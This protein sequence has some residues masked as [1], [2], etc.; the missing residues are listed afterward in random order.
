LSRFIAVAQAKAYA[1]AP[2][3]QGEKLW[4][5]LAAYQNSEP[6]QWQQYEVDWLAQIGTQLGIGLQ[7]AEYLQQV[8]IQATQLAKASA[9]QRIAEQQ[10]RLDRVVNKIRESLDLDVIFASATQ[11]LR[12]VL[13]AD[14][15]VI[16]RFDRN[17][18]GQFIAESVADGWMSIL[19][20][21]TADPQLCQ[22]VNDCSLKLL[23]N[24]SSDTHLKETEGG[25]FSR[26]EVF[27]VCNDVQQGGFSDCYLQVLNTYQ[28]QAY[29]IVALFRGQRLWGLLAAF[30]N[31]APRVWQEDEVHLLTE[32]GSHLGIALQQAGYLKQVKAQAVQLAKTTQ[33]QK[34]LSKTVDKIRYSLD[35]ETIFQT[36]TQEVRQLLKSDRVVIY[37][38]NPDWSGEFVAESV[39]E[40]WT[41]LLKAQSVRPELNKNISDCS[42]KAWAAFSAD[43]YLQD[44]KGGKF[45]KGEPF[46]VCSDIYQAGFS[47]CYV[48]SLQG[49]EVR[50]YATFAIYH[51]QRLWGL[52]AAYQNA[53]PRQWQK[54]EIELLT[55]ISNHLGIALQQA[56]YLQ[57]VTVQASQLQLQAVQLKKSADRQKALVKTVDKIRQ[58]LD[59][60]TIFQTTTH[61]VRQ[62]LEVERVAIYRFYANWSGEFVADSIVDGW[63]PSVQNQT[64]I[65]ADALAPKQGGQYPRNETFVP[66]LQGEKL[67]GLLVASQSSQPRYWQEEEINLLAQVGSQ[68][69]VALQ[70]AE[71][72][73]QTQKQA[74]ELTLALREVQQSQ[75]QLIQGEKMAGLGQLVAG[76][77]HEIN[78]PVNFIYGNLSHVGEYAQDLLD[79]ADLYR[80]QGS[81]AEIAERMEAIDLEF[82]SQDLPKTLNS[83]KIGADR[84]RQIVLSLRNFSRHDEAT[85]KPVDIHEGIDSTLMILQHRIKATS[86]RPAINLIKEYGDLPLVECYP[87]QLNQ[88][89]MNLLSNG[90][91]ALE[92]K[93]EEGTDEQLGAWQLA[94]KINSKLKSSQGSNPFEDEGG[95]VNPLGN[96]HPLSALTIRI[97][98]LRE[99]DRVIIRISDDGFGIPEA[100]RSRIFDPFFTTKPIGKGTGLGLSISHQIVVDKHQG[101]FTCTSQPGQGTEFC[102][103]IP[104]V[105]PV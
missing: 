82:I 79:L 72:L 68:L 96:D 35:I 91:D 6:R 9:D 99:G 75:S 41:S 34:A 10:Q 84:I 15:V 22:N 53:A 97:Q 88:V 30:Q 11:E 102:I 26:G 50:A 60:N 64:L 19:Q 87:A 90:I 69:G 7:Q 104:I 40:G 2:I 12:Q 71:L 54:D 95:W 66:I 92:E 65:L 81:A 100:V 93:C 29:T 4:G 44:T 89:F 74:A 76:V 63:A 43:T 103:E 59:I 77:A 86:D 56:E 27:R 52:L 45:V 32:V 21:Q 42:L 16:Y 51:G 8:Q 47:D 28:A 49:Y 13:Q 33:R 25:V 17:W 85:M 24:R 5:L 38:F 39:A 70:Q 98:T 48:R 58:S 55:E 20:R 14:R 101:K 78:N 37:R 46:S 23:G 83:M 94:L 18:D 31:A 80:N 105:Q 36:T 62:F 61:E 1:I 57:Q 67:W 3:L 73:E